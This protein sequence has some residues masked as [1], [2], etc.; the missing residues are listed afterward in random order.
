MSPIPDDP[1]LRGLAEL[2]PV[3]VDDAA[4]EA[5]RRRARIALVDE[6]AP[7]PAFARLAAAWSGAVLPGLLLASGA[8]YAWT[9]VI[10]F[11]RIF[12]S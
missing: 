7:R 8:A 11:G 10:M 4:A 2:P 6:G 3:P 1:L 12:A 9:S 5:L